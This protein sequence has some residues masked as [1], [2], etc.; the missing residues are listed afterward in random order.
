MKNDMKV[1]KISLKPLEP[2]FFGNERNLF[3]EGVN[4]KTQSKSSGY[5]VKSENTPMQSTLFGVLR[6]MGIIEKRIDFKLNQNDIENIGMS[7]FQLRKKEQSFGRI[8]QIS[9]LYLEDEN[10]ELYIRV[11]FDQEAFKEDDTRRVYQGFQ[12]FLDTPV[13]TQNGM[14]YIPKINLK[15]GFCDGYMRVRDGKCISDP[16]IFKRIIQTGISINKKSD[17]FFKK[18]YCFLMDFSFTFYAEV[19]DE[20]PEIKDV[21]VKMGQ[22]KT[23]FAVNVVELRDQTYQQKELEGMR[24]S[25]RFPVDAQKIV[26]LSDSYVQDLKELYACCYFVHTDTR[27]YRAMETVYHAKN[28]RQRYK[29]Q[30]VLLKL[31]K[32]GSVFWVRPEKQETFMRLIEDKDAQIAGFNRYIT[33]GE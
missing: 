19:E 27:D 17:A 15:D 12:K 24:I 23:A 32:A 8:R 6:Y 21:C 20:F 31:L 2:Y 16:E 10:G 18:E 3:Y 30:E 5:F 28:Q 25:S 4:A 9:S 29:K 13:M 22:G 33:G 26:L 7:S 14:R 11:P 1:L